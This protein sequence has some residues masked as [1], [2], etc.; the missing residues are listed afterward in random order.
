MTMSLVGVVDRYEA[1]VPDSGVR[2][3]VKTQER[4]GQWKAGIAGEAI[5]TQLVLD[6]LHRRVLELE[7]DLRASD[8]KTKE[9]NEMLQRRQRDLENATSEVID[10]RLKLAAADVAQQ[11]PHPSYVSNSL[12]DKAVDE[13]KV[14]LAD[15]NKVIR[16]Y[17]IEKSDLKLKLEEMS[18][19]AKRRKICIEA[20]LE[21]HMSGAN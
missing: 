16:Q 4:G 7:K 14:E 19:K 18:S 9:A 21:P 17:M 13:H 5:P 11:S 2:Q 8:A 10:L 12:F 15:L 1:V 3:W 6:R 20:L